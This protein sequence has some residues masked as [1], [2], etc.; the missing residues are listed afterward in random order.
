MKRQRK[1]EIRKGERPFIEVFT[2]FC[3]ATVEY[4]DHPK[5]PPSA[6]ALMHKLLRRIREEWGVEEY[7]FPTELDV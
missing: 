5:T 1:R 3:R 2:D 6:A 7:Q 4:A